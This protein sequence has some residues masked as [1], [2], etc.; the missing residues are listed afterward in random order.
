M[1][2]DLLTE[3]RADELGA[4]DESAIFLMAVVS[5]LTG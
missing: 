3:T 2:A 5:S 4:G 1:L